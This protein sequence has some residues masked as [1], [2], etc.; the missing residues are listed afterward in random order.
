M[1]V[2]ASL[3]VGLLSAPAWCETQT[4]RV[5]SITDGDTIKVVDRERNQIRI[6]LASIDSPEHNQA[7]GARAK[8]SLSDL[9][10]MADV[11][12]ACRKKMSYARRVCVV[13][14]DGNDINLEQ[15]KRGMGWDL[16]RLTPVEVFEA[17][18][19]SI[20]ERPRQLF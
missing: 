10:F 20:Y 15:L 17:G 12:I 7:F 16:V 14:R 6:R 2:I 3:V 19:E 11:E 4:V 5:V 13:F 18:P 1:K 9:V 8:K